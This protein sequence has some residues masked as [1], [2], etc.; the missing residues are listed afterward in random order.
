M[1][2][3][4]VPLFDE[5]AMVEAIAQPLLVFQG[6]KD[7]AIPPTQ[8][9]ALERHASSHDKRF[10]AIGGAKHDWLLEN[11]QSQRAVGTFLSEF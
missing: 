9:S 2:T 10:V 3:D 7:D 11:A 8:G 6:T 4:A 1:A 5:N